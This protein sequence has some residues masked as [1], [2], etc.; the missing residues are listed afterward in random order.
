M[1]HLS[2]WIIPHLGGA[3]R[4]QSLCCSHTPQPSPIRSRN[5]V[6]M[7]SRHRK[8]HRAFCTF[9]QVCYSPAKCYFISSATL[10]LQDSETLSL[11]DFEIL[12]LWDSET[13]KHWFQRL[14]DPET[15]KCLYYRVDSSTT[16]SIP[17]RRNRFRYYRIDSGITESIP[18]L[19]SRFL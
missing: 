4:D 11:R 18:V 8:T 7:A 1:N 5:I 16:E 9:W 2:D 6:H 3:G 14:W 15:L 13:P 12:K 10:R 19:Q 17:V